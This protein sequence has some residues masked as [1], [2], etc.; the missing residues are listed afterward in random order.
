MYLCSFE[1]AEHKCGAQG[2]TNRDLLQSFCQGILGLN[3]VPQTCQQVPL[4]NCLD[5]LLFCFHWWSPAFFCTCVLTLSWFPV[6]KLAARWHIPTYMDSDDMHTAFKAP[7]RPEVHPD[8]VEEL[9]RKAMCCV[10]NMNCP[11]KGSC[12]QH[13]KVGLPSSEEVI[14]PWGHCLR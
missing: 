9:G 14:G 5:S 6:R 7:V 8:S 13:S 12:Q 11:Q 4:L 10:L 2:A 1:H 3:S